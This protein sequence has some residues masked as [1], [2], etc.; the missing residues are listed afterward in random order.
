MKVLVV[1]YNGLIKSDEQREKIR[2]E[3]RKAIERG[4]FICD[5]SVSVD[6]IDVEAISTGLHKNANN[7]EVHLKSTEL[8]DPT[9]K[10][11]TVISPSVYTEA[12]KN[13]TKSFQECVA[14]I[15]PMIDEKPSIGVKPRFIHDEQRAEELS[16]AIM[17]YIQ[18]NRR[19]PIEWLE[20]Y[21]ELL[22]KM[23]I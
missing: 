7:A 15:K 20:E 18:D 17:S 8:N 21:N 9:Q 13:I 4:V 1:K 3:A 22:K 14:D 16:G 2:E 12:I 11:I 10:T 19:I 23:V 6:S 5:E